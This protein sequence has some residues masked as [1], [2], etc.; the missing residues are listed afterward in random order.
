MFMIWEKRTGFLVG[1]IGTRAIVQGRSPTSARQYAALS[2]C[3]L[4]MP[5]WCE[6]S[7]KLWRRAMIR[8]DFIAKE[9]SLRVARHIR[10][11]FLAPPPRKDNTPTS[12]KRR[13]P[14]SQRGALL[15][16][17]TASSGVTLKNFHCRALYDTLRLEHSLRVVSHLPRMRPTIEEELWTIRWPYPLSWG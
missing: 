7:H 14:K 2:R 17:S 13:L 11:R 8:H 4:Q 12:I 3:S 15:L 5:I 10:V 9:T 1:L 16:P 6:R